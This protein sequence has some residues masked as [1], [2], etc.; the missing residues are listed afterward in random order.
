[1]LDCKEPEGR[2]WRNHRDLDYRVDNR[3][4]LS[5]GKPRCQFCNQFFGS[6]GALTG[7]L[8]RK[9]KIAGK[10][11]KQPLLKQNFAG[12]EIDRVVKE[13]KRL[14][15]LEHLDQVEITDM[16]TDGSVSTVKLKLSLHAKLLGHQLR[17]DS[18]T[19]ADI[20]CRCGIARERFN[21]LMQF[22]KNKDLTVEL[23]LAYMYYVRLITSIVAW[24]NEAWELDK[25]SSAP[26]VL[27][28]DGHMSTFSQIHSM[29]LFQTTTNA[30]I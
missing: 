15:I 7:H 9:N 6:K 19:L 4:Y 14:A 2:F 3:D 16:R 10:R 26:I 1:L 8:N 22:W 24:G 21:R 25:V 12:S 29:E 20:K 23:K 30:Y 13:G 17:G 18:N 11:R 27:C 28:C 5:L